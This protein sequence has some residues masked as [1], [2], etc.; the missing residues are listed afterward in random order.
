MS[1]GYLEKKFKRWWWWWTT[2]ELEASNYTK[3]ERDIHEH[4][5]R[6]GEI[7]STDFFFW[8]A[9][10][11]EHVERTRRVCGHIYACTAVTHYGCPFS[12]TLYRG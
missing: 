12:L 7:L 6:R 8:W 5:A 4:R 9:D 3:E 1:L 10:L 11:I 2:R